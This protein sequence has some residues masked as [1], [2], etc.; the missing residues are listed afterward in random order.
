VGRPVYRPVKKQRYLTK[1][2]A[3]EH[4]ALERNEKLNGGEG[5]VEREGG[6]WR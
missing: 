2:E 6:W 4:I 1:D 3:L 5:W